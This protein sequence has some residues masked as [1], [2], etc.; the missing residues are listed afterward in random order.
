M[1]I[2]N[3]DACRSR[4]LSSTRAHAVY[5]EVSDMY[6]ND[7]LDAQSTTVTF[8][9]SEGYVPAVVGKESMHA[10]DINMVSGATMNLDKPGGTVERKVFFK[11]PVLGVTEA[12]AMMCVLLSECTPT[13]QIC[14]T[15]LVPEQAA[16]F[17]DGQGGGL[18]QIRQ[19]SMTQLDL[20]STSDIA[21]D[22]MR[23]LTIQGLAPKNIACAVYRVLRN[24]GFC[25]AVGI[26]TDRQQTPYMDGSVSSAVPSLPLAYTQDIPYRVA[27]RILVKPNLETTCLWFQK[28]LAE[29][30]VLNMWQADDLDRY[31]TSTVALIPDEYVCGIASDNSAG[32]NEIQRFTECNTTFQPEQ[33]MHQVNLNERRCTLRGSVQ[34]I[35]RALQL[36]VTVMAEMSG[37]EKVQLVMVF[38]HQNAGLIVGKGGQKLKEIRESSGTRINLEQAV[39][40]SYGGRRLTIS[41]TGNHATYAAYQALRAIHQKAPVRAEEIQDSHSQLTSQTPLGGIII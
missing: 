11:G 34:S 41:G 32:L 28:G 27:H 8:L 20:Q 35:T 21:Y 19:S 15:M 10:N 25:R 6:F 31:V 24:P 40:P 13:G 7:H 38:D 3:K 30:E 23:R 9:V 14:I 1:V 22:G 4:F 5:A 2:Q 37:N 29:L 16:A 36:L 39:H 17:I 26:E 12:V 18:K 33:E